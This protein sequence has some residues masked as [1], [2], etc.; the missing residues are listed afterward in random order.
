MKK[1]KNT[2]FINLILEKR[3]KCKMNS[4]FQQLLLL[5]LDKSNTSPSPQ[6]EIPWEEL[7]EMAKKQ[8]VLGIC[9]A[10]VK[11]L[12]SKQLPPKELYCS[13][14]ATVA[15]IQERNTLFNK[16]CVEL[17]EIIQKK[18]FSSCILKGQSLS[19][20][21]GELSSL[22]QSGDI[23]LWI[24]ASQEEITGLAKKLNHNSKPYSNWK[25]IELSMFKDIDIELH[26]R[27]SIA[28]NPFV[29]RKL[30]EYYR[31]QAEEQCN[32]WVE[33]SGGEKITSPTTEFNMIFLMLHLYDHFLYEG[34][35]LRQII[36]FY[37][38]LITKEAQSNKEKIANNYKEFGIYRFSQS[39][40]YVL[41]EVLNLEESYFLSPVDEK[42]GNRL[43][44]EIMQ[45]GNFGHYSKENSIKK[46]S[47][48]ERMFRRTKHRIRLLRYAPLSPLYATLCKI[49]YL[50]GKRF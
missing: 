47:F 16:K 6:S 7:F 4:Y 24:N 31:E 19:P 10:G 40:M 32:H 2:L 14:L 36:D 42:N 1:G 23:D 13:W 22:R 26:W 18:G 11:K 20:Y 45:G 25:H 30:R 34:I 33:L 5:S 48:I 12:K 27:P 21:Y 37:F 17:Q 39:V 43:L 41:R 38:V 29:N 28:H 8:G 50:L 15:T 46:E 44:T 35:G 49:Q 3:K 9:F